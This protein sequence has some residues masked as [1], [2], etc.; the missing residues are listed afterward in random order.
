MLKLTTQEG[1]KVIVGSDPQGVV[2]M[3]TPFRPHLDDG[4]N[5]VFTLGLR[6]SSVLRSLAEMAT[7]SQ[8]LLLPPIPQKRFAKDA[9]PAILA[10]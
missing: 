8:F 6:F 3:V 10:E 1:H 9:R 7:L 5:D 4:C 2:F